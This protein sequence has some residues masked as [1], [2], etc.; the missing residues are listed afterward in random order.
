MHKNIILTPRQQHIKTRNDSVPLLP[1]NKLPCNKNRS[2]NPRRYYCC[3]YK[4]L[5]KQNSFSLVYGICKIMSIFSLLSFTLKIY[6]SILKNKLHL[7]IIFIPTR[8][9]KERN[10][11][12]KF[13]LPFRLYFYF[14]NTPIFFTAYPHCPMS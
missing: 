12:Y 14:F 11:R 6:I 5:N 1:C 13:N 8:E 9:K 2:S 3:Y 10:S 7:Y 4:N